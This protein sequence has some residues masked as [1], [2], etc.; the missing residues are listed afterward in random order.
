MPLVDEIDEIMESLVG[1]YER[2]MIHNIGSEFWKPL[3][4]RWYHYKYPERVRK[5]A[6][7]DNPR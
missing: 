5:V 2:Y 3:Y 1:L 4:A 7:E 6:A